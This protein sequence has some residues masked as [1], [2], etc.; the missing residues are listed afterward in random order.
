MKSKDMSNNALCM[1]LSSK[2]DVGFWLPCNG[3]LQ[4]IKKKITLFKE[5][6]S[7]QNECMIYRR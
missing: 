5:T 2:H 3:N 1:H 6:L 7:F 4:K